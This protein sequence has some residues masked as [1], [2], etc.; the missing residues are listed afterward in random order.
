MEFKRIFLSVIIFSFSSVLAQ[1]LEKNWIE[2]YNGKLIS[3]DIK[4]V[5]GN[6]FK[7]TKDHFIVNDSLN[8]SFSD[9]RRY[10][11]NKG[12]F[13]NIYQINNFKSDFVKCVEEGNIDL[14]EK[15]SMQYNVGPQNGMGYFSTKKEIFFTKDDKSIFKCKNKYLQNSLSDNPKAYKL[16]LESKKTDNT[17]KLLLFGGIGVTAAGLVMAADDG[18]VNGLV[19]GGIAMSVSSWIPY[20]ISKEKTDSAIREY[21]R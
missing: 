15:F 17:C 8:F 2:L 14:F 18:N 4:Q 20:L 16:I 3:G 13:F 10:K 7:N 5:N 6:F 9:V 21:N 11:N 1:E 12:Y 19:V